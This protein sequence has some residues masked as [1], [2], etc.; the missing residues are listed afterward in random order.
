MLLHARF[1]DTTV[2]ATT[3][4]LRAT[5]GQVGNLRPIGNRPDAA[6]M[7]TVGPIANRSTGFQPAPQRFWPFGSFSGSAVLVR[8]LFLSM[9]FAC[10][11][12]AQ[13]ETILRHAI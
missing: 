11:A 4:C 6:S 1:G 2:C 5:V 8:L 7:D 13:P 12:A 9:L 3:G 10:G